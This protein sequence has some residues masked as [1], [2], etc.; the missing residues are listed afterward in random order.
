MIDIGLAFTV[1]VKITLLIAA[2]LGW[3]YVVY[4]T[5]K[6]IDGVSAKIRLSVYEHPV[7]TG[8]IFVTWLVGSMFIL[9]FIMAIYAEWII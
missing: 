4:V 9:I 5:A 2:I 8:M 1:A 7:V 3:M 6:L